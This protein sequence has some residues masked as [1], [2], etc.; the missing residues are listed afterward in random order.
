MI[1]RDCLY[2]AKRFEARMERRL[3]CSDVCRVRY[4][5]E[6]TNCFYCGDMADTLDHILPV[7]TRRS[8]KRKFGEE[9]VYCCK[10]C[11]SRLGASFPYDL[12]ERVNFLAEKLFKDFDL[13]KPI[14]EW[15]DEEFEEMGHALRSAVEGKIKTRQWA[16]G[17]WLHVKAVHGRLVRGL[18]V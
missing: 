1:N 17:R 7:S 18:D 10:D 3:F 4:N 15:T 6:N 13:G 9:V 5:R 12:E 11:N 16:E 2:C 8:R 14:P